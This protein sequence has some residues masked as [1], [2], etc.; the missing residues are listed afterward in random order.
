MSN[1]ES[2]QENTSI[3]IYTALFDGYD[4]LRLPPADLQCDFFCFTDD[5]ALSIEGITCRVWPRKHEDPTRDSRMV[6]ILSHLVLPE[7]DY[8]LWVDASVELHFN[9][10]RLL[11]EQHLMS[12][13]LALLEHPYN[14]NI[15]K[16][17][18]RCLSSGKDCPQLMQ[19]Q[20]RAYQ[21]EGVPE[22]TGMVATG[23]L[24]RKNSSPM[25]IQLNEA[26]WNEVCQFSRRD[27]LSFN[28]VIWRQK[29]KYALMDKL[30][31]ESPFF[32]CRYFTF[33]PHTRPPIDAGRQPSFSQ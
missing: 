32:R 11:I 30:R 16:E 20:V 27:Q 12:H 14:D 26:W 24:L 6:K 5:P 13:E 7:Y 21:A 18:E 2:V 10:P 1:A 17:L 22:S 8:T 15:Y 19:A 4:N 29:M 3:A 25:I 9:D 33:H 31:W 23:A 28:P